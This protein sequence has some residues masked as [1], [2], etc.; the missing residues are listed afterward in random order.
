MGNS[1]F[2]PCVCVWGGGGGTLGDESKGTGSGGWEMDKAGPLLL[3]GGELR[4]KQGPCCCMG[5]N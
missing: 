2:W 5:E 3:H 1:I 4:T